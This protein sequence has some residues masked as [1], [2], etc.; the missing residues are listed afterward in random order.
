MFKSRSSK[1]SNL[2]NSAYEED[3]DFDS[4]HQYATNFL[5][6]RREA[7]MAN[8]VERQVHVFPSP[9][10]EDGGEFVEPDNNGGAIQIED[11]VEDVVSA[12]TDDGG[13][14]VDEP[15]LNASAT[16][17]EEMFFNVAEGFLVNYIEFNLAAPQ[18]G[19]F[20]LTHSLSGSF[21]SL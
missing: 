4:M 16:L 9:I 19:V 12:T 10:T 1:T 11:D 5:D 3:R 13:E 20:S 14:L 2:P 8:V 6:D 21:E 7:E 17:E 18:G 15:L